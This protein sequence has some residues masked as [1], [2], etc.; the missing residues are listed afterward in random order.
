MVF[1]LKTDLGYQKFAK[2]VGLTKLSEL[3]ESKAE[4]EPWI[5]YFACSKGKKT[6]V[7]AQRF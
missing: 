5:G 7:L 6:C 1:Q 4:R 3:K 2:F